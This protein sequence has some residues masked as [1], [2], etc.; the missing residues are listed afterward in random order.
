MTITQQ[1]VLIRDT[2]SDWVKTQDESGKAM[3]A[4]SVGHMWEALRTNTR[5]VLAV[6]VYGGERI[7]GDFGIAAISGRVD[8]DWTVAISRGRGL[9]ADVQDSLVGTVQDAPPLLDL[10]WEAANLA[11]CI[12]PDPNTCERPVDYKG[13]RTMQMQNQN[14]D[15]YLID[16]SIGTQLPMVISQPED[17]TAIITEQGTV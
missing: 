1:A 15:G 6:V 16:F 11:R 5:N 17:T 10:I 14:L 9:V 3:V 4:S 7:R 2:F 12:M 13:V 8:R